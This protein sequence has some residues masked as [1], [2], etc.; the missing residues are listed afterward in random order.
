MGLVITQSGTSLL[1]D[2]STNRLSQESKVVATRLQD[3]F[4]AVQRDLE[5]IARSPSV[6]RLVNILGSS[7]GASGDGTA[8]EQAKRQLQE[9]FAALLV[10][11]PWYVQARL[12]GAADDGMEVVRVD[13]IDN[14]I[15]RVPKRELQAKGQRPYFKETFGREPGHFYWSPINLNR[16]HGQIAEPN[17][18]ILR[19]ALP[20]NSPDDTPFG[21]VV[22]NLDAQRLFEA[23]RSVVSSGLT[24]YV[25]NRQG[26]YLYH[27]QP[28]KTFGF[29][30]GQ[31][32][33]I[34]DDFQEAILLLDSG[35]SEVI[36][37][38]VALADT[39]EPVVAYLGKLPAPQGA[40]EELLLGLTMPRSVIVSEVN[41]AR[42]ESAALILP[43]LLIGTIVVIWLVRVF[44][45][46]LERVTREVSRFAPGTRRARLPEEDR[47]DEVGQ[48]AQA[49]S[50][51]AGRLERQVGE[52]K[53]QRKRFQSLFET[54]PDA[55]IIIDEDGTMEYM[56]GSAERL[57][58]YDAIEV[59]GHDIKMLMPE[60]DSKH[61]S[62]Y[63]KR[64]L[65]GGKP[66]IIGI[67][68]EVTG[69]R[70]DGRTVALYLS[71]G[72]F[73]LDG[74]RKFTGILHDISG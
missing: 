62:E 49:F 35:R 43:F 3:I 44:I 32:Y 38:E 23:I 41:A 22:I 60:P 8:T 56:N 19:V 63:M 65:D 64:Y 2:A 71:I 17:Q 61:H 34:Q 31:R 69:K 27:P 20:I 53:E 16:E 50:L 18:P 9:V 14:Q 28:D 52:L 48:L 15:R 57:F 58:G 5:F 67:G 72:E 68:R 45:A 21:I 25:A 59:L 33:R 13:Q 4:D 74:R 29:E 10:N 37:E 39:S 55:I 46:P 26:D 47:H 66:H 1:M 6:Q 36:E 11:H 42:R 51:M 73:T 7:A 70:K 30:R 24:F 40:S 54:A 12:I